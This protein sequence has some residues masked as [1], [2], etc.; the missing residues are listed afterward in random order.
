MFLVGRLVGDNS[1]P[2]AI[3]FG[4]VFTGRADSGHVVKGKYHRYEYTQYY[5]FTI[6]VSNDHEQEFEK[7]KALWDMLNSNYKYWNKKRKALQR[8]A[9]HIDGDSYAF[10]IAMLFVSFF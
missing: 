6:S 2:V 10:K 1:G 3:E 5:L 8:L 4:W 9:Q 7:E